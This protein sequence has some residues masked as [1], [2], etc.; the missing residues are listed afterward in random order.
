MARPGAGAKA[1]PYFSGVS[2][3]ASMTGQG[4]DRPWGREHRPEER[5]GSRPVARNSPKCAS[6]RALGFDLPVI[7]DMLLKDLNREET[8]VA[9]ETGTIFPHLVSQCPS[10]H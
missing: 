2:H 8:G 9:N 4:T 3:T 7:S 6:P 10:K 5:A 1:G